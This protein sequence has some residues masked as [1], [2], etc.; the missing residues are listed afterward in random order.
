MAESWGV[1]VLRVWVRDGDPATLRAHISQSL[2][3]AARRYSIGVAHGMDEILAV[4]RTW[5]G[6]YLAQ[7][8]RARREK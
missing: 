4:V 2:E 1:L 3:V 6:A 7:A 5:L 8:A